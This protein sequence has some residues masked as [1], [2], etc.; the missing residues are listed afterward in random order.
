[1]LARHSG[2]HVRYPFGYTCLELR[3]ENQVRDINF[4]II[5][6]RLIFKVIF[7]RRLW[8][9][10]LPESLSLAHQSLSAGLGHPLSPLLPLQ[11][12][13]LD[14]SS[15][16]TTLHMSIALLLRLSLMAPYSSKTNIFFLGTFFWKNKYSY[17]HSYNNTL[18]MWTETLG[19]ITSCCFINII[20]VSLINILKYYPRCFL[21][22]SSSSVSTWASSLFKASSLRLNSSE[23]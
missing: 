6:I 3:E 9:M 19:Q 8:G 13:A 15:S 17:S 14:S 5:S 10:W 16:S 18:T 20:P 11:P 4:S 22:G 1:M 7:C 23:K 2:G 21:L 12:C